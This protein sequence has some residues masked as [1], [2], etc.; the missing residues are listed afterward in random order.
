MKIILAVVQRSAAAA[1]AAVTLSAA[2]AE[3]LYIE[4]KNEH[5]ESL[6]P[7]IESHSCNRTQRV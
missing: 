6:S 1:E 5:I 2:K 3:T 4:S 7:Y